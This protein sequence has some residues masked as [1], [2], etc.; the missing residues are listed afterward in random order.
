ML[1][2]HDFCGYYEWTFHFIRRE[3]GD[4]AVRRFW[5]DGIGLDSQRHYLE[6]GRATGLKGLFDAWAHTGEDEQCDWTFT[7]DEKKNV[8]R[9]DMRKCPSK[10]FLLQND[11]NADEDY[12]DHCI[13]WES[14]MLGEL[15]YEMI[16]HEHNHSG[17]CWGEM[18]VRGSNPPELQLDCDIRKDPRWNDGYVD[19][20]SRHV[21]LPVLNS[22][23]HQ[24]DSDWHSLLAQK[25]TAPRLVVLGRGPSLHNLPP[26]ATRD[27]ALAVTGSAFAAGESWWKTPDLVLI[28]SPTDEP[29]LEGIA[30]RYATEPAATA[31]LL[32]YAFLPSQP[33]VAFPS[34]RL[35]RPCP[36]L[37]SLI[38]SG[39]YRHIPHAPFPTTGV[40]LL[41]LAAACSPANEI[42]LAGLDLY[43][44]PSGQTYAS[45]P[46]PSSP[47]P[48]G[49]D[50]ASAWPE[51]H[52]SSVDEAAIQ[53][54][55]ARLGSR[56][57]WHR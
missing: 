16:R 9:W 38:R 57:R 54:A 3:F 39:L 33:P 41:L 19:G 40:F 42:H 55:V 52:A 47:L 24:P 22:P 10:G 1:G 27:A 18:T 50:N 34:L 4:V 31:P 32:A 21:K 56:L 53:L 37:P 20:F 12:C 49:A 23:R 30:R 36:I 2:C 15:G 25:L 48:P 7:L 17:Q 14:A 5:S 29:L 35:P 26:D 44:H 43:S 45:T 11:L 46:D 51:C 8:L 28:N 6:L 13:G